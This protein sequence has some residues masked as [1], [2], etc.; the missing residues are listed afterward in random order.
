MFSAAGAGSDAAKDVGFYCE[1]MGI[2][3]VEGE[4]PF[5]L[6]ESA[7]VLFLTSF[8]VS[9]TLFLSSSPITLPFGS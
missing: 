3:D 4:S 6:D 7:A 8:A 5:D 2:F 9:A 1:F